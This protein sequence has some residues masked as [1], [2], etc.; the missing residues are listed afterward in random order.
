MAHHS[1]PS[2]GCPVTHILSVLGGKWK[3]LIIYTRSESKILR[4]GELK[5]SLLKLTHKM[6]GQQLIHRKEYQ[7]IPHKV[8]YSLTDKGQTLLPLLDL[9]CSWGAIHRPITASSQSCS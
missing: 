8:E 4:Y 5:K 7:Q 1:S 9:M 3:R 6:L 2:C